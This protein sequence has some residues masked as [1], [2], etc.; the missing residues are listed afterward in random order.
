MLNKII[1][2]ILGISIGLVFVPHPVS[3]FRG[4]GQPQVLGLA[5]KN[6]EP[7]LA[8][9]PELALSVKS[10]DISARAAFAF[11]LASG[12]ILYAK[13]FDE[14]L[15]IASLTK[16]ITAIIVDES[17][18]LD[19]VVEV[20][21]TDVNVVGSNMGLVPG[22]K[23]KVI[24][25][26]RGMLI[27]SSNDAALTLANFVSGSPEKF[28]ERM[29]EKARELNLTSTNFNNPV[30]WDS[31]ENYSTALDLSKV[32]AEF[33]KHPTLSEIVKTKE[34][35]IS[36][37]DHVFTHQLRTTNKLL[38]EDQSISGI[39]T[40]FT[41]HAKGSLILRVRRGGGEIV[42]IVLGSD[43]REDDSHKLL[44]W[45]FQVYRW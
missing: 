10:P 19:A 37:V 1:Y 27:P 4:L 25:L 5:T 45:V 44:E 31:E 3:D 2:V 6:S 16:L 30:G 34:T 22:E 38:L 41:S 40:G 11:D 8:P 39:K 42:T 32:V 18:S 35:N 12:S 36:S 17:A 14:E 43:N 33:L 9:S 7:V 24:D 29:N 23:I 13:S 28:V 26:L 21:K 20:K 15:P